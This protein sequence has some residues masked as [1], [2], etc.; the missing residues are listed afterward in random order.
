MLDRDCCARSYVT[1]DNVGHYLGVLVVIESQVKLETKMPVR[2]V[3][4]F[5][6]P[7]PLYENRVVV[8]TLCCGNQRLRLL[9]ANQAKPVRFNDHTR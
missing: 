8:G 3:L 5:R 6:F 9:L 4:Q 7:L 2:V 1:R